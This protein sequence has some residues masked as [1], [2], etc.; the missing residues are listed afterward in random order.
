MIHYYLH[1]VVYIRTISMT[2]NMSD[3]HESSTMS[4]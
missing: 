4:L 2:T 3:L 1:F